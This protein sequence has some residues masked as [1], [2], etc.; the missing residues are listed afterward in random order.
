MISFEYAAAAVELYGE[1]GGL[2]GG[3]GGGAW[4]RGFED[5]YIGG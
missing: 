3:L 1:G 5:A 2:G 4:V